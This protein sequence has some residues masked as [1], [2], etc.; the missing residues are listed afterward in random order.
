MCSLGGGFLAYAP[1][2]HSRCRLQSS[3]SGRRHSGS[4]APP[5][6]SPPTCGAGCPTGSR[7]RTAPSRAPP[8][9]RRRRA[10]RCRPRR[11]APRCRRSTTSPR[12]PRARWLPLAA[13]GFYGHGTFDWAGR[14]RGAW[15][16]RR[17]AT[18]AR[19]LTRPFNILTKSRNCVP[20]DRPGVCLMCVCAIKPYSFTYFKKTFSWASSHQASHFSNSRER[21]VVSNQKLCPPGADTSGILL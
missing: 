12:E 4:S 21:C 10:P 14:A 1:L 2:H 5:P 11:R 3:R 9:A 13:A 18:S 20:T 8:S 17:G 15:E 19:G 7:W 16:V 6:P